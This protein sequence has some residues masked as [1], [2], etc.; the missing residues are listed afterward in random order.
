MKALPEAKTILIT[1]AT[2]GI[3]KA[4]VELFCAKGWEVYGIASS[5]DDTRGSEM[6]KLLPNFHYR[7]ADVSNEVEIAALLEDI[8]R[9]DAAFNN[10][11]TGIAP[12]RL[13]EADIARARRVI[14]VNLIGTLICMKHEV[15]HTP[16]QGVVV[17]NAS[18]AAFKAA[19]GADMSYSASKAGVL[20]LTAEAAAN[21]AYA[22]RISFFSIAPGYIETRMTA[23]DDKAAQKAK[24]PARRLGAPAEVAALVYNIITNHYAFTSGQCFNFDGGAFLI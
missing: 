10:A 23:A 12:Q 19:T 17:N 14:D 15:N 18:L 7:T 9:L 21:P 11:G 6:M 2:H 5:T 8:G 4:A 1:G 3:G 22:G 16:G 24:L 20:A 13:P